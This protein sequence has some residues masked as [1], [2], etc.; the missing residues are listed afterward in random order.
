MKQMRFGSAEATPHGPEVQKRMAAAFEAVPLRW[1][2]VGGGVAVIA[3]N[4]QTVDFE[5]RHCGRRHRG[6]LCRDLA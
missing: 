5:M 1:A 4:F 6:S 2:I 3:T